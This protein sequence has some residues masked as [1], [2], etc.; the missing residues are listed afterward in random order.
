MMG[1]KVFLAVLVL[2]VASLGLPPAQPDNDQTKALARFAKDRAAAAR[3]T[4]EVLWSNYR[5]GFR[6]S[7]DTL[8]RWS[9][10]W[11]EAERDLSKKPA[12]QA[13]A[14]LAHRNRM[15]DLERLIRN[16]R[17]VGQATVDDL[18]AAEFYKA[19]AEYWVL[20]AEADKKGP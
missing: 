4:Y 19:E 2:S 5:E 15:G 16:V 1:W 10:R 14:L 13:A 6:I 12:D 7:H 20:Q 3:K 18:S 8:Y 17:R 9:R 11:L